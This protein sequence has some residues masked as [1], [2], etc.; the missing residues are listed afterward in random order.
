MEYVKENIGKSADVEERKELEKNGEL[1][2]VE[3]A[4]EEEKIQ[5]RGNRI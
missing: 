5:K 3:K 2:E 4:R 1:E